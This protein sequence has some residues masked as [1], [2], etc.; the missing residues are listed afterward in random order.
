M[1]QRKNLAKAIYVK[2]GLV[3]M[4]GTQNFLAP[5]LLVIDH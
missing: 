2:S 4:P 5:H 1:V 3:Q